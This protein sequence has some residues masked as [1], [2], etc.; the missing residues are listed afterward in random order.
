MTTIILLLIFCYIIGAFLNVDVG[1]A[2][3][4]SPP[5]LPSPIYIRSDG[6]VEPQSGIQKI[7]D[8]YNF[9]RDINN[10]IE[11]Q[12]D[13]IIIEGNGFSITQTPIDTSG[14]MTPLGFYPGIRLNN[15]NN[16]TVQNVKIHNCI[17]GI[18][19]N[20]AK[21]ITI[22]N[23]I[24]TS[25]SEIAIFG[26][27]SN[28]CTI[29][30]NNITNNHSGIGIQVISTTGVLIAENNIKRN[31]EG[32]R[33]SGSGYPS[34]YITITRNNIS[35]NTRWGVYIYQGSENSVVGNNIR[36][37]PIGLLVKFANV[38]VH[39]NNFD[40]TQNVDNTSCVGPWDDGSK[41]NYWSDYNGTD[42]DNDGIGDTAYIVE[43]LRI[44]IE[45]ST[46]TPVTIGVNAQ[47]NYP[48]IYT[49]DINSVVIPEFSSW[50]ILPLV[51]SATLI[52]VVLK[53]RLAK[54]S[55]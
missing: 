2:A 48:L 16:V 35:D 27:S 36:N 22:T 10:Y 20:S 49:V 19:F 28:N 15:R 32:I 30:Q 18:T 52:A 14:S 23:N 42:K 50:T 33:I 7:G 47:D 40:N 39:H 9:T 38:T 4:M 26:S 43:T 17:S 11:V 54:T 37:N 29:T 25:I 34:N 51:L 3:Y 44:W 1:K 41:G 12:R 46:Q 45:P 6:S 13:N 8:T 24:I 31:S 5:E 53:K 55:I 21:N